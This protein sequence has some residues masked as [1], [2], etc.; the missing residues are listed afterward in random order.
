MNF[1]FP[2]ITI[3]TLIP[4]TEGL[5][6]GKGGGGKKEEERKNNRKE[7]NDKIEYDLAI[8]E[9]QQTE[10]Q[11]DIIKFK[12]QW[13]EDHTISIDYSSRVSTTK[14]STKTKKPSK[15][16]GAGKTAAHLHGIPL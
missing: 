9:K 8:D 11:D 7:K 6:G 2:I 14:N 15:I 3:I 10:S 1:V 4:I 12:Q 5:F 16:V 13:A